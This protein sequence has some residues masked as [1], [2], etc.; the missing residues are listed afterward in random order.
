M[1]SQLE[2]KPTMQST[3][4]IIFSFLKEVIAFLE[5]EPDFGSGIHWPHWTRIRKEIT[6]KTSCLAEVGG[7]ESEAV[8]GVQHPTLPRDVAHL[9]N[10]SG[11]EVIIRQEGDLL[12]S[13]LLIRGQWLWQNFIISILTDESFFSSNL[14]YKKY[15][16]FHTYCSQK[17]KFDLS[18]FLCALLTKVKCTFMKSV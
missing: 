18:N 10:R 3:E 5:S 4:S 17:C 15:P 2:K 14:A 12:P 9:P 11:L 1:I 16:S 7:S 8:G 13:T 6:G